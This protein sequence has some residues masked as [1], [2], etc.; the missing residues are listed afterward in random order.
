MRTEG[1]TGVCEGDDDDDDA[2]AGGVVVTAADDTVVDDAEEDVDNDDAVLTDNGVDAVAAVADDDGGADDSDNA[3]DDGVALD[4]NNSASVFLGLPFAAAAQSPFFLSAELP[5]SPAFGGIGEDHSICCA[6]FTIQL[7]VFDTQKQEP[8]KK[9]KEKLRER[10]AGEDLLGYLSM[11]KSRHLSAH[12]HTH[13]LTHSI[14]HS[15]RGGGTK[16]G[17][18]TMENHRC[19]SKPLKTW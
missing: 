2:L 12:T 11:T 13:T 15:E 8:K 18:Q 10:E 16:A 17:I 14:T 5:P 1:R 4:S 6:S 19:T 9:G 3:D 7:L